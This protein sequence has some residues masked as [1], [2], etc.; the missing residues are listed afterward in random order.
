MIPFKLTA[1][2]GPQGDQIEAI[3]KISG[4]LKKGCKYQTLLGVTGSGKTYTMARAIEEAGRPALVISHNKTLAAQLY[5]EFTTFFPENAVEYFVSYYDYYQPEAYLPATDTYIEKDFSIN[6]EIDRMRL[7]AT[8]ALMEREDVIVVASV[9]CIYG[10]GNPR[11]YR[12][13]RVE[14]ETGKEYERD[15]I[16]RRLVDIQYTRNDY[17]LQRSTF[18]VRGEVIEI[19]PSYSGRAV[20]IELFGDEI[21]SIHWFDPLTGEVTE[22]RESIIIYPATHYV[23][24]QESLESA[25]GRIEEELEERYAY[26]VSR[27]K[28]LEA[29]RIRSRTEYD[30][31]MLREVGYCNGIENYSRHIFGREAGE[32][33]MVLLDYFPDD[34]IIFIDESHVTVPQIGG[35]YEGDRSRKLSLVEHG[36]RLPSALDNRPLYFEEFENLV[37]QV[38]FVSATPA[39]FERSRSQI[40]A[41]QV[42]RPTGLLDPEIEVRDSEHQIDNLIE[43]IQKRVKSNERVLVTTLTKRMAEDLS[44]FLA[45][46]GIK[47]TY[48]HSEIETLER[49]DILRDLRAGKFDVLVGINLLREGLDLPEVSLVAILDADKVGFL[50]SSTSLIQTAGRAARHV[51]GKVLMYADRISNAMQE[52][53]DE[54]DRRRE[55]QRSYN[56]EHG[57]VPESIKK[58]IVD[59]LKRKKKQKEVASQ[60]DLEIIQSRYNLLDP[61]QKKRYVRELE[62]EMLEAS[63]NLDYERAILLRDEITRARGGSPDGT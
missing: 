25:I 4:G 61:S 9:S 26:L 27:N 42:I 2:F 29:Q 36:F 17:E 3:E 7:S 18:R 35:M 14:L 62:V 58:N 46:I 56:I 59:I 15:S 31:E 8:S 13:M 16:L 51:E 20:R 38:V 55:I 45:K 39:E 53:I 34:F 22:K 28:L 50:R 43:E 33:P 52:A 37:N 5:R 47:V 30:L 49:V 54:T 23:V 41:E 40:I 60:K 12:R 44:G 21:E 11:V 63:K 48:L 19:F 6:D 32:R 10:V 1:P 24:E 57:I